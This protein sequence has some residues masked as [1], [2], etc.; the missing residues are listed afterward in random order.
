[1]YEDRQVEVGVFEVHSGRPLAEPKLVRLGALFFKL[2]W[3]VF[4]L[5]F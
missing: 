2:G 3:S 5:S 1:M 4:T